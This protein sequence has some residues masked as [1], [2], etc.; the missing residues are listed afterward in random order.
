MSPF[1]VPRCGIA[2]CPTRATDTAGL[3]LAGLQPYRPLRRPELPRRPSLK[4]SQD[5]FLIHRFRGF[6][7]VIKAVIQ[8]NH[9]CIPGFLSLAPP[10]DNH[11]SLGLCRLLN[12]PA[13][14][15]LLL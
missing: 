15:L 2:T 5:K 7:Y 14:H 12:T 10:I 8:P 9:P 13:F 6:P 4:E 3:S 11:Q 1:A